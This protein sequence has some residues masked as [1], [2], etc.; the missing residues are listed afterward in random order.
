MLRVYLAALRRNPEHPYFLQL[1]T[2]AYFHYLQTRQIADCVLHVVCARTGEAKNLP[3]ELDIPA[4]ELWLER[5]LSELVAE[6][7]MFE[8]LKKRRK[9]S[10]KEFSFPFKA[11]PAPDKTN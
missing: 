1:R 8:K 7:L 4:Y 3:V 9:K 6:D 2:Y 5:R 11:N 10:S